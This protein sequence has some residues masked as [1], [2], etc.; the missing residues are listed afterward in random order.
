MITCLSG[1]QTGILGSH[2]STQCM[3]GSLSPGMKW[4]VCEVDPLLAPRVEV[5]NKWKYTT[6]PLHAVMALSL[7][8]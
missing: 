3:T 8:N 6:T 4:P 5:K 7:V 2:P 1:L